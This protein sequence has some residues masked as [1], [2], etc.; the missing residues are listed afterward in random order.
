[1]RYSTVDLHCHSTVS[2]G[3]LSPTEVA[4]R[5]YANG[6]RTWS[7]TDHDDVGG[8][9]EASM[10]AHQLGMR[11]ITGIEISISWHQKT[12]HMVGLNYDTGNIDLC[13]GLADMRKKR[14]ERGRQVGKN[15]EKFGINNAYEGAMRFAAN[16][17]L[18]SRTH[19][20]RYIVEQGHCRS[21]QEV[22][23]IY[24][25]DGKPANVPGEWASFEQ[26]MQWVI[27]AGGVCLIAH[28]GRYKCSKKEFSELFTMFKTL[29]GKGIEVVTG[30]HR[31]E[32]YHEFAKVAKK[33]D[34]LA[35]CGSDFHG[36]T[37]GRLDLGRFPPL[38]P[39]LRAV[40]EYL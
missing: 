11:Y 20:A 6:V 22:F 23:D 17:E 35:S 34:F 36:P 8:Q 5:A 31:P 13:Q 40:W 2:D 30:S 18:L 27:S 33:Y 28:P 10:A 12:I 26:A 37:E 21:L 16:P 3:V 39:G 38:P 29:G 14:I 7:L 19:F 1:M 24:L 4:K 32:Q 25:G 15:L 9:K